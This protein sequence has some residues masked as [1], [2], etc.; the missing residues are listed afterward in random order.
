MRGNAPRQL[1]CPKCRFE[2][3]RDVVAV[4]N[5]EKKYLTLMGC[6]PFTPMPSD[7]TLEVVVLPMREWA[8][9]KPLDETLKN[10][11]IR[12]VTI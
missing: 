3:G 8:R 11:E 5:F 10:P 2:S 12:G 7:P 6:M 1:K 4:L 9:R